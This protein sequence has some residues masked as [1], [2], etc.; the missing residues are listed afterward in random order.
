LIEREQKA[1]AKAA[2]EV[3]LKTEGVAYNI[4]E[5]EF[6]EEGAVLQMNKAV[7]LPVSVSGALML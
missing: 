4:F 5:A 7:R 2:S 6:I 3:N 1:A